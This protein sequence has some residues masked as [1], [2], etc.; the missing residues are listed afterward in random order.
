[1]NKIWLL[2]MFLSHKVDATFARY[3]DVESSIVL[4]NESLS[5]KYKFSIEKHQRFDTWFIMQNGTTV[6][7]LL[8]VDSYDGTAVKLQELKRIS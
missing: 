7:M 3:E 2:T 5:D 4:S 6:G 8:L 1:M